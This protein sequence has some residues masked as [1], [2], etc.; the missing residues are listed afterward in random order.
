[1]WKVLGKDALYVEIGDV[2]KARILEIL[3]DHENGARFKELM[4]K[5][6]VKHLFNGTTEIHSFMIDVPDDF[7]PEDIQ[8]MADLI[9]EVAKDLECPFITLEDNYQKT[10][11]VISNDKEPELLGK[12]RTEGFASGKIFMPI[13][14][15]LSKPGKPND[16]FDF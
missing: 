3:A 12:E 14:D 2:W 4:D 8:F 5:S 13:F 1:M 11:V 6:E 7:T 10:Q 16:S 15:S 9:L